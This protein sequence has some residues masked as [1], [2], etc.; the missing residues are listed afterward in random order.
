M[1][2]VWDNGNMSVAV[3]DEWIIC[4]A[5]ELGIVCSA[6]LAAVKLLPSMDR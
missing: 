2:F 5:C 4:N 1:S 3:F 6:F